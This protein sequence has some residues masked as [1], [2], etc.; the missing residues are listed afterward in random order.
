MILF[1]YCSVVE[2]NYDNFLTIINFY[3]YIMMVWTQVSHHGYNTSL[4]HYI[5]WNL[6]YLDLRF[7][8]CYKLE[9]IA[10]SL[11]QIYCMCDILFQ[12]YY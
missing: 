10:N 5:L 12:N 1:N 11:A 9:S 3:G 7:V 2:N 6:K 8:T 4:A